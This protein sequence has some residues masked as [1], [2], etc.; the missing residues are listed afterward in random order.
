MDIS[1]YLDV[2]AY[3]GDIWTDVGGQGITRALLHLTL[4]LN[5]ESHKGRF[6]VR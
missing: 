2:Y 4:M 6:L 1:S 3:E 5:P